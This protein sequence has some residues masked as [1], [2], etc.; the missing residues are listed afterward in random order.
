MR[1]A[2]AGGAVEQGRPLSA[3]PRRS[4]TLGTVVFWASL[5]ISLV[6]TLSFVVGALAPLVPFLVFLPAIVATVGTLQ[7][8]AII[9]G[10]TYLVAFMVYASRDGISGQE[11]YGLVLAAVLA[12]LSIAASWYRIRPGSSSTATTGPSKRTRWWA[13]TSTKWSVPLSG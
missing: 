3:G 5:G 10:W 7:Q 12:V 9:A 6:L 2:G 4:S 8:T 1:T 11:L 13:A